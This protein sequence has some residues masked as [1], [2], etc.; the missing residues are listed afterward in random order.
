MKI[1]ISKLLLVF[2]LFTNF[3]ILAQGP[4]DTDGTPTDDLEGADP[5]A[6]INSY[7]FLL[8]VIGMSYAF[9]CLKKSIS[10]KTN[11]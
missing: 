2:C 3:V 9:I 6:P 1:K 7:F 5:V 11:Y 10:K 4:G 8:A